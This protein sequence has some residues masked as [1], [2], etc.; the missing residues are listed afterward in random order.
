MQSTPS[1]LS[2]IGYWL[3]GYA[4]T[5]VSTGRRLTSGGLAPEL[6]FWLPIGHSVSVLASEGL[7]KSHQCSPRKPRNTGQAHSTSL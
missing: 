4:V 6:R 5:H 7:D 3:V 1:E 2:A